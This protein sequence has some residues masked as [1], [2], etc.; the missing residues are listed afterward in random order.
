MI[1]IPP[2]GLPGE[3]LIDINKALLSRLSTYYKAIFHSGFSESTQKIFDMDI[4]AEDMHA[5]RTWLRDGRLTFRWDRLSLEQFVRLYVFADYYDIPALRRTIMTALVLDKY[6]N[7]AQYRL[8]TDKIGDYLS[9]LPPT[10]P[11]FQWLGMVWARHLDAYHYSAHQYQLA[12][13]MPEDLRRLVYSIRSQPRAS[14]P[15]KCCYRPCDFHEHESE[16]E[17]ESSK[18]SPVIPVI[19]ADL[20]EQLV[21]LMKTSQ[22]SRI[23][24]RIAS[25]SRYLEWKIKVDTFRVYQNAE[26]VKGDEQGHQGDEWRLKFERQRGPDRQT[27]KG[28]RVVGMHDSRA[29]GSLLRYQ[30]RFCRCA[31]TKG[32]ASKSCAERPVTSSEPNGRFFVSECLACWKMGDVSVFAL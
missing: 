22:Q 12:N 6:G 3:P 11:L 7:A 14:R 17:W 13:E 4:C 1:R 27:S 25:H 24:L 30:Q 16:Q 15:C 18:L 28:T 32:R 29:G 19:T 20:L 5:F 10:S 8:L 9:Q 2:P 26:A 23:H 31:S 21:V